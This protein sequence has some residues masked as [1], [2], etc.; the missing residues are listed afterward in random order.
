M[1]RGNNSISISMNVWLS[2][3]SI[4]IYYIFWYFRIQPSHAELINI[5]DKEMFL[6]PGSKTAKIF[7]NG[8][9]IKSKTKLQH[10]VSVFHGEN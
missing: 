5:N 7:V 9:K 1:I 3:F 2:R 10:L 6:E 4:H 8:H